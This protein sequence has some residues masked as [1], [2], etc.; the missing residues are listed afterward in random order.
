MLFFDFFRDHPDL[1]HLTSEQ[2]LL[3]PGDENGYMYVLLDGHMTLTNEG[4]DVEALGP[5]DFFGEAAL[6]DPGPST[7]AVAALS[8]CTLARISRERFLFLVQNAPG[9]AV[10][11]IRVMSRRLRGVPVDPA[12]PPMQTP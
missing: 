5:G 1:I 6:L 7:V 2:D 4:G 12:C 8:D 9:F 11:V 10:E 3:R